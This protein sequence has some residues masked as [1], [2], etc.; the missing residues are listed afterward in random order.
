MQFYVY[1]W[2]RKDGSPY[3][4]GKGKR[5]RAFENHGWGHAPKDHTRIQIIPM[6]DEDVA[7]AYERYL[8]D[9]W[10][11]KDNKTGI[12]R[13]LTDGGENPPKNYKGRQSG[14]KLSPKTRLKLSRAQIGKKKSPRSKEHCQKLSEANKGK[15]PKLTAESRK[16]IA[17]AQRGVPRPYCQGHKNYCTPEGIEKM[18]QAKIGSKA[19]L[20]TRVQMSHSAV[21]GWAKRRGALQLSSLQ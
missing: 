21:L 3:Y 14:W 19:S 4:V 1:L 18:R 9:F 13:N 10:G 15:G 2:S 5:D 7:L 11:R 6:S 17:E 20:E 8:I 12:L 16:K